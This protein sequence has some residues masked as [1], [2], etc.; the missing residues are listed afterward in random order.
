M[1]VGLSGE[2]EDQ[3]DEG[4]IWDTLVDLPTVPACHFDHFETTDFPMVFSAEGGAAPHS[5]TTLDSPQWWNNNFDLLNETSLDNFLPP[6]SAASGELPDEL[7]TFGDFIQGMAPAAAANAEGIE[8]ASVSVPSTREPRVAE[9]EEAEMPSLDYIVV[10]SDGMY[11]CPYQGCK[12]KKGY[13]K[14]GLLR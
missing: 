10:S 2:D 1:E 4:S 3:D 5:D 8:E 14:L 6:E 9:F 11:H 12:S 13:E 7:E